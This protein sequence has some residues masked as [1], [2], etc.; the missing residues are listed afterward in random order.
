[1]KRQRVLPRRRPHFSS[2]DLTAPLGHDSEFIAVRFKTKK[3][4]FGWQFFNILRRLAAI[5]AAIQYVY[6]YVVG[7]AVAKWCLKSIGDSAGFPVVSHRT[8]SGR[9]FNL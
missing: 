1:M 3:N 6:V 8:V 5:A 7:I 2:T 4:R 9:R